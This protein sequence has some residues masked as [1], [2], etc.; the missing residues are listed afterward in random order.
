MAGKRELDCAGRLVAHRNFLPQHGELLPAVAVVVAAVVARIELVDVQIFL[1]QREDREPE[2]Q[3]TVVPERDSRQRRLARADHVHAGCGQVRDVAQR[4][5]RVPAV[6]QQRPSRPGA[7]RRRPSCCCRPDRVRRG[8]RLRR[9][10]RPG[11]SRGRRYAAGPRAACPGRNRPEPRSC[12][13]DPGAG[14]RGPTPVPLPRPP[15]RATSLSRSRV[16]P[17][18]R[19]RT[20]SA[21]SQRSGRDPST[22]N[23]SGQPARIPLQPE[24]V[25]VDAGGEP[26]PD[27]LRLR[28]VPRPLDVH[29]A[30]VQEQ[31]SRVILLDVLGTEHLGE[32]AQATPA[33]TDRSGTAVPARR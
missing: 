10:T 15:A 30:A 3:R 28:G 8:A 29:V 13:P 12:T 18:L 4:R 20:T 33:A 23:S 32:P 6:R 27:L 1:V 17:W 14:P 22:R 2:G 26:G 24:D 11:G 7:F 21:G 9:R 25:G 31:P 5:H 16:M 19:M